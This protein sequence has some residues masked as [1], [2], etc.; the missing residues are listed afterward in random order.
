MS[1]LELEKLNK[2]YDLTLKQY[3]KAMNDYLNLLPNFANASY[4]ISDVS[5]SAFTKMIN[6]KKKQILMK[7]DNINDKL[8]HISKSIINTNNNTMPMYKNADKTTGIY[9]EGIHVSLKD[10][11][12]EKIRLK[13]MLN[14][15]V[16]IDEESN[17]VK[18]TLES[19]YYKF[20]GLVILVIFCI[21]LFVF[22]NTIK[23]ADGS[24]P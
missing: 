24:N 22:V 13:N 5:D 2:E 21:A 20:F 14:S 10:L 16:S 17:D 8:I 9:E 4:N 19:Y 23:V 12:T 1:S 7:L 15:I 3:N 18:L 6:T 11:D